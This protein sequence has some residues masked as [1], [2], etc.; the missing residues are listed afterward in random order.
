MSLLVAAFLVSFLVSVYLGDYYNKL[1]KTVQFLWM[2]AAMLVSSL[3]ARA[4]EKIRKVGV[5]WRGIGHTGKVMKPPGGNVM[6]PPS[7]R[8]KRS[9]DKETLTRRKLVGDLSE[10]YQNPTSISTRE[11]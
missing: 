8:F 5:W 4:T 6:K 11:H 1:W 3:A 7:Q 2:V 10:L 9:E